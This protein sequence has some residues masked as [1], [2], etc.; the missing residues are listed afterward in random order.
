MSLLDNRKSTRSSDA[1][2]Q[3]PGLRSN[4]FHTS[5]SQNEY[6]LNVIYRGSIISSYF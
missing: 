5:A 3:K 2:V 6:L 1:Y 4:I